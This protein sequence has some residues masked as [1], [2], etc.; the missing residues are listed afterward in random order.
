LALAISAAAAASAAAIAAAFARA[1]RFRRIRV[2]EQHPYDLALLGFQPGHRAAISSGVILD[3]CSSGS[4]LLL[5]PP[6]PAFPLP[7]LLPPPPFFLSFALALPFAPD[8][9]RSS[10][11]K[12]G[13]QGGCLREDDEE[14]EGEVGL[15]R[16]AP[17]STGG[18]GTSDGVL[19]AGP[20]LFRDDDEVGVWALLPFVRSFVA[21]A[22]VAA[23]AAAA[24]FALLLRGSLQARQGVMR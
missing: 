19:L 20:F 9:V 8:A 18:G 1:R 6:F 24:A 7:L 16:A 11:R 10:E 22:A 5:L 23:A 14:D 13:G 17:D 2:S 21:A 4:G 3:Q 12:G 15:V